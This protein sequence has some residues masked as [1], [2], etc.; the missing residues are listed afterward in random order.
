MRW[1]N[2]VLMGLLIM[3]GA[4]LFTSRDSGVLE[5]Q[6]AEQRLA[7]LR[8]KTRAMERVNRALTAEVADLNQG[9]DAVEEHARRDLGM[10]KPGE[11]YYRYVE[12]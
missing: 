12:K 8:A 9:L 2:L 3:L 6:K 1:F 7:E 10:V 11:V 4:Q 5:V